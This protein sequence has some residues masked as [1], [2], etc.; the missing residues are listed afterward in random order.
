MKL[1]LFTALSALPLAAASHAANVYSFCEYEN[2]DNGQRPYTQLFTLEGDA[3][4]DSYG[5]FRY[6]KV[7]EWEGQFPV[8][9]NT[10]AQPVSGFY[11]KSLVG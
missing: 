3:L 2:S 7:L 5:S 8:D 4:K 1:K 10:N 11:P 9:K 6:D